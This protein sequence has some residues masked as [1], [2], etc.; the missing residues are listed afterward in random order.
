MRFAGVFSRSNWRPIVDRL[1]VVNSCLAL[2][3][4]V[5]VEALTEDHDFIPAALRVLDDTSRTVQS[6][7]YWF[8]TESLTVEPDEDGYINLPG[9]VVSVR[10][11]DHEYIKRGAK[12]YDRANGTDVFEDAVTMQVI[13]ELPFDELVAEAQ[14]FI[15]LKTEYKFQMTYDGDSTKTRQLLSDMTEARIE[16]NRAHIRN[17]RLNV[18]DN[19]VRLSR[20]HRTTRAVRA[21]T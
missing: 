5:P 20:L 15:G 4:E 7:G 9:D 10:I 1:S 8:N 21:G 11:T 14:T 19:H 6:K 17:T 3:G 13:R 18:I 16:L 2:M 12:L